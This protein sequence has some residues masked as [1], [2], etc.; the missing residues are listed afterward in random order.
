M[1]EGLGALHVDNILHV[2]GL[3]PFGVFV[4]YRECSAHGLV[5][6]AQLMSAS[7]HRMQTRAGFHVACSLFLKFL[8]H[9][10]RVGWLRR[11]ELTHLS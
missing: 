8:Q 2:A 5:I 1:L 7:F 11:S 4:L 3:S 10:G 6:S 9:R